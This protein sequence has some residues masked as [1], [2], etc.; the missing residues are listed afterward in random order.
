MIAAFC[1]RPV[2]ANHRQ[3]EHAEERGI[4]LRHVLLRRG[5]AAKY[6]AALAPAA[7][8]GQHELRAVLP[9]AV[10]HQVDRRAAADARAHRDPFDDLGLARPADGTVAIVIWNN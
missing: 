6:A 9:A 4:D 10:Q 7:D 2:A 3:V 8:A 1:P 5:V